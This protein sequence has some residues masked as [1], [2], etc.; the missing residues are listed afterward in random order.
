MKWVKY[1]VK[2]GIHPEL[3]ML[4][5]VS[6]EGKRQIYVSKNIGILPGLPD[7]H[8]PVAKGSYHGFWLEIKV[9]GKNPTP[10]Q[11]AIM[12]D[13]RRHGHKVCWVDSITDAISKTEKYLR[14]ND[15]R[16]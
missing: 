16:K 1:V 10:R 13:L 8:L 5:H 6:N 11:H 4:Y 7:Y 15:E 2:L 12:E 14:G 9:P 3:A